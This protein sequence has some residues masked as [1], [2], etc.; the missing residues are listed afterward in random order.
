M[1]A[2]NYS[3]QFRRV[4]QVEKGVSFMKCV[5]RQFG[6]TL[7]LTLLSAAG[8]RADFVSW[9][10]NWSRSPVA[11]GAS[12]GGTGGLTLTDEPLNHAD[13]TSDIVA[14]NIRSFSSASRSHPDTFTNAT[15]SLHLN[16]T[17]TASGATANMTFTGFFSGT[18]SATSANIANTFT[19]P[20]TFSQT[21]GGHVYTVTIGA[22]APP[23]PPTASNA[24]SIS[25]HVGV[26]EF[27]PPGPGPGPTPGPS[28]APEPS[29]L[30]LSGVGVGLVGLG[31]WFKRKRA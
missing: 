26:D 27:T 5:L 2:G 10:Y 30:L 13:G 1:I 31:R 21:L 8:V 6:L 17:D 25:A 23:G 22:Y 20:T 29:T 7:A 24:G 12:A 15:Y 14:T 16:L 28:N 4:G 19:G 9:S 3:S 11:V 18:L